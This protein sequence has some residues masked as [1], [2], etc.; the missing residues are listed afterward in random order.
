[1]PSRLVCVAILLYW[2]VAA[3]GLVSRDLIPELT[4][5]PPPDLR[6]IARAAEDATPARWNILVADRPHDPDSK[7]SVGQATTESRRSSDGWI[8]MT[9]KVAFHLKYGSA[10]WNRCG[11]LHLPGPGRGNP[12]SSAG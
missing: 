8:E 9:S 11:A 2:L 3:V 6:T 12:G 1:M 7:R 4:V 5:G 10:S